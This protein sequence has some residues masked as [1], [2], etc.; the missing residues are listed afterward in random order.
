MKVIE[1]SGWDKIQYQI[2]DKDGKELL[3]CQVWDNKNSEQ[4]IEQTT[5]YYFKFSN[6]FACFKD[7]IILWIDFMLRCLPL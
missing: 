2:L 5:Y 4:L 7:Q 1:K 6:T 3:K